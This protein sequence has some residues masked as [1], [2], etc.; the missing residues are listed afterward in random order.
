M[1]ETKPGLPA[2]GRLTERQLI[3]VN[4]AQLN[5][6]EIG[7]GAMRDQSL[8][9]FDSALLVISHVSRQLLQDRSPFIGLGHHNGP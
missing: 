6:H 7:L 2:L 1:R 4:I 3:P 5:S 8:I 9:D